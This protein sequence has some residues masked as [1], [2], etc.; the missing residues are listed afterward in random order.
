[1]IRLGGLITLA[2]A[3]AL[4]AGAAAQQPIVADVAADWSHAQTGLR[5]PPTLAG[6]DRAEINQFDTQQRDVSILYRDRASQT[7][8]TLYV[9]YAGFPDA[10]V[11]HDRIRYAMMAGFLGTPDFT[12]ALTTTFTPPNE[13]LANGL[14]TTASMSGKATKASG[15]AIFAHDGWLVA[16]RMSSSTLDRNALDTRL[17]AFVAALPLAAGKTKAPPV[18]V[19]DAC[20]A[21]LAPPEAKPIA[22]DEANALILGMDA[23][24]LGDT[25]LYAKTHPGQPPLAAA[26]Y[27]RDGA[28]RV[29]LGIYR[30]DGAT[31]SYVMAVGDAGVG[32]FVEKATALT[33]LHKGNPAYSVILSTTAASVAVG[34]F[35][36]LP[37]LGQAIA[38][39]NAHQ[40]LASVTRAIG[41]GAKVNINLITPSAPAKAN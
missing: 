30:Q 31:D 26:H 35:D 10:S 40:P 16:A 18:Y 34:A 4:P 39:V 9:F 6:F 5:L 15:V 17:A 37:T 27:C 36:G 23:L 19:I 33:E 3:L 24:A 32:V 13:H 29:N 38:A 20:P 25:A 11:W 2:A 41:P 7:T 22:R 8:T 14:R 21:P 28:S 12:T 1:V